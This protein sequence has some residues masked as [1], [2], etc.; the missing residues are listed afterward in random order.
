MKISLSHSVNGGTF[1]KQVL[2]LAQL[3]PWKHAIVFSWMTGT[4]YEGKPPRADNDGRHFYC[5][6][7]VGLGRVELSASPGD[8]SVADM[9]LPMFGAPQQ[10]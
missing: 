5:F 1:R 4:Y 9:V 6:Q 10:D 3:H 2:K 8:W 7:K